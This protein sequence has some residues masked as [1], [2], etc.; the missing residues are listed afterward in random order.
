MEKKLY[1]SN[2]DRMVGGVCGG[3][4]E[5]FNIDSSLVRLLWVLFSLMVGSGLLAYIIC[6]IVIP[7]K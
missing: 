4:A 7:S 6:L 5:Y 3:I 2:N 1:R